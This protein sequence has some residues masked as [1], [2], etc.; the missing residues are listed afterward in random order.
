MKSSEAFIIP[1]HV[2]IFKAGFKSQILFPSERIR[3]LTLTDASKVYGGSPL[4]L[5]SLKLFAFVSF[6]IASS[7]HLDNK[8]LRQPVIRNHLILRNQG[9]KRAPSP[10]CIVHP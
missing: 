5:F 8:T 1:T 7:C 9:M 4:P 2:A 3:Y 10:F 6:F